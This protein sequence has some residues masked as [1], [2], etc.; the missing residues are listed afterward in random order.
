MKGVAL[1]AGYQ[2]GEP[3]LRAAAKELEE[4]NTD[5]MEQL[6]QLMVAVE[7]I[8][9]SWKGDAHLAFQALMNRFQEDAKVLN[10]KL[11]EIS[12]EVAASADLYVRQE[13][14]AAADLSAITQTLGG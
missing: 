8:A 12:H 11:V 4:G 10:D 13:Q 1:M 5:L 7:G 3:E 6:R 2:A 9:G 14:E